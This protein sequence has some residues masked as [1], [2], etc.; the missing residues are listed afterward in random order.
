MALAVRESQPDIHLPDYYFARENRKFHASM[1]PT[2][3]SHFD[4]TPG[5]NRFP[6]IRGKFTAYND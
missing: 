3:F 1:L 4:S 5:T 2:K 6:G